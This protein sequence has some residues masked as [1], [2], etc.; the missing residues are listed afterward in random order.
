MRLLLEAGAEVQACDESGCTVLWH[1]MPSRKHV[2]AARVEVVRLLLAA[3]AD[4]NTAYKSGLTPLML[5]AFR[6]CV[7]VVRLLLDAGA[8]INATT[9]D[10]GTA[11][12]LAAQAGNTGAVRLLIERGADVRATDNEGNTALR[13]ARGSAGVVTLLVK[14]S[15][16][17]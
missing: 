11:L 14:A 2:Q 13:Q 3:D 9:T 17:R 10:G 5:A 15:A 6:G 4:A 1:A 16:R 12:M 7:D 8:N